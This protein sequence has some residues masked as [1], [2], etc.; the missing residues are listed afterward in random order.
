MLLQHQRLHYM[1]SLMSMILAMIFLFYLHSRPAH[2]KVT[3]LC[4]GFGAQALQ[5]GRDVLHG[6]RLGGRLAAARKLQLLVQRQE[7]L[8][9][10]T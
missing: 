6:R 5:L 8:L 1:W 9:Q 7:V 4:D 10:G 3:R 2:Q